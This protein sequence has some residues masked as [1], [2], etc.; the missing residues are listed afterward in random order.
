MAFDPI[1]AL[2]WSA[3]LN[4]VASAPLM[5]VLMKLSDDPKTVQQFRLP[6]YLRV[7]GWLATMVMISASLFL[8]YVTVFS[9]K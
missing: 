8:L 1:K 6:Q 9:A 4:G 2:Y 3:V 7:L 5:I